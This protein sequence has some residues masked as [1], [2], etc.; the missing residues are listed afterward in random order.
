[1]AFQAVSIGSH[2]LSTLQCPVSV[3]R[4]RREGRV[5]TEPQGHSMGAQEEDLAR[6]VTD[7]VVKNGGD[8]G[9]TKYFWKECEPLPSDLQTYSDYVNLFKSAAANPSIRTGVNLRRDYG[10]ERISKSRPPKLGLYLTALL[11]LGEPAAGFVWLNTECSHGYAN[12]IG[13]FA[14][15]PK[16]ILTWQDVEKVVTQ[17]CPQ[18]N[19]T[20]DLTRNYLFGF[21]VGIIIGDGHKPKQ[22]RGHRHLNVTLSKRYDTNIKIGDFTTFCANQLGLR[23]GRRPD[24]PKPANKPFGFYVWTSQSSPLIDWIFNIVLGLEDGQHT[25]YDP[26][27]MDWAFEAP[28]DFR[29]GSFMVS[30]DPMVLSVW[31]VRQWSSG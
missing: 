19:P 2:A 29:L 16:E 23:M 12:P 3:E 31:R 22:G 25:T 10:F 20:T 4:G 9:F 18:A 7:Y 17:L 5:N 11:R 13:R 26:I 24:L 27:H 30:Q 6:R 15:V 14:Q 8:L 21:L 1:M 28:L